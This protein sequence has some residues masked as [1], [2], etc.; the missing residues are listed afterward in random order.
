M[1]QLCH[2]KSW[3]LKMDA[4]TRVIKRCKNKDAHMSWPYVPN[5]IVR[6]VRK[7]AK[8]RYTMVTMFTMVTMEIE[9]NS[10]YGK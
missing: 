10:P 3:T 2:S 7:C 8:M 1:A 5:P 9:Q 6:L 4:G